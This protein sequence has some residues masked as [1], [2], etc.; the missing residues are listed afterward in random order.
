MEFHPDPVWRRLFEQSYS[1]SPGTRGW[2]LAMA[3]NSTSGLRWPPSSDSRLDGLTA[4]AARSA[5]DGGIPEGLGQ[6][7]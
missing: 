2:T 7:A 1:G 3:P 6:L 4:K 5:P